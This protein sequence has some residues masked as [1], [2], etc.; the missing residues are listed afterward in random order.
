MSLNT[1]EIQPVASGGGTWI[2]PETE[3]KE[4]QVIAPVAKTE[5]GN[6]AKVGEDKTQNGN[7]GSLPQGFTEE[8]VKQLQSM[9]G[10]STSLRFR[11]DGKGK[12]SI[13]VVDKKTGEVIRKIPAD[14]TAMIQQKLEELRGIL[15]DDKV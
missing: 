3:K 7:S 9:L 8:V 10:D 5:G 6:T 11:V 14:N 12:T 4:V 2:P 15:F 13:T 1:G